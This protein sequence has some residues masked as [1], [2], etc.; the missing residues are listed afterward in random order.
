MT[1]KEYSTWWIVGG[2][3][4][5]HVKRDENFAPF[6]LAKITC[7]Q[8]IDYASAKEI[9]IFICDIVLLEQ[10]ILFL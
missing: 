4:T 7:K 3:Q 1:H 8:I 2:R 10:D 9:S 6:S 5:C